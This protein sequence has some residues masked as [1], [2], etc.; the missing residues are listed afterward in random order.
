MILTL[1][2]AAEATGKSKPTLL[3]AI[4]SSKISATRDEVTGDWRVDAAE[5]HR[6]YPPVSSN[7]LRTDAVK[8]GVTV[9]EASLKR[10]IEVRDQQFE[11]LRH[12]RERERE[13]AKATIDDLRQRLDREGEER[14]QAQTQLTALLTDQNQTR[15]KPRRWVLPAVIAVAVLAV[16][17]LLL[18]HWEPV[19]SSLP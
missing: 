14:R 18:A 10:E 15:P 12:E 13:D 6:V 8:S 7:P 16:L 9:D 1:K 19:R 4:Q 5:L 11:A 3:R 17:V 2:Q